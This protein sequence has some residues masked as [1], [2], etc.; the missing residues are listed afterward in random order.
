[1]NKKQTEEYIECRKNPAWFMR[2]YGHIRHPQKGI[3]GFDLWDFQTDAVDDFLNHS[4]NVVLKAR[5]MGMSTLV[6]GYAAWMANFFKNKE[7]YILATKRDT[8]QNMVDK[9]RVFLQGIPE[10]MLAEIVTDNK[11]SI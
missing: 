7:I 1:M 8:A 3:I 10:W 2:N 6:A 11:Q 5:Q 9:V 4:Y